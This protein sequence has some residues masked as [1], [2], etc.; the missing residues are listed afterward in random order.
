MGVS[1]STSH[2]VHSK[3]EGRLSPGARIPTRFTHKK[4]LTSYCLTAR[5][6]DTPTI[7]PMTQKT[8]TH[9]AMVSQS[10]SE[11]GG[12]RYTCVLQHSCYL[13]RPRTGPPV[14]WSLSV[15]A[16][17]RAALPAALTRGGPGLS[18]AR[19]SSTSSSS[20]VRPAGLGMPTGKQAY[21]QEQQLRP[22]SGP[23]IASDTEA[24]RGRGG[25]WAPIVMH[26]GVKTAPNSP[27]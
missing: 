27:V 1:N 3:C 18:R 14:L 17:T 21:V 12:G 9:T 15:C 7:N 16:H 6:T 5:P 8:I 10:S 22:S 20:G 26:G 25:P 13:L 4:L 23:A 2:R 11:V 19:R 24:E